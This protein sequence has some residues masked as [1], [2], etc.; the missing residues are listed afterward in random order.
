MWA[1]ELQSG[2]K[3]EAVTSSPIDNS[4]T[5][6]LLSPSLFVSL[7]VPLI[8]HLPVALFIFLSRFVCVCVKERAKNEDRAE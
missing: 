8:P 5:P 2:T 6:L 7:S 1:I 4:D 3:S